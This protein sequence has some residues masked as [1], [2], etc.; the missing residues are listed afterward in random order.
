MSQI[1]VHVTFFLA[2]VSPLGKGIVL[3]SLA[4][5]PSVFGI[6]LS[7][8]GHPRSLA[9][10]LPLPLPLMMLMYPMTRGI[11]TLTGDCYWE[12][13]SFQPLILHGSIVD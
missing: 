3:F 9:G 2:T 8:S 1:I 4:G 5:T 13:Y 11:S 12:T 6:D 10:Q 7:P